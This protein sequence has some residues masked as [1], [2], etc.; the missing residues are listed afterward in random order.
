MTTKDYYFGEWVHIYDGF[1]LEEA[2]QY[3]GLWKRVILKKL[4]RAE[5]D[6]EETMHRPA[7]DSMFW[8]ETLGLKIKVKGVVGEYK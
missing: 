7:S 6:E 3:L 4:R 1:S 5:P 2:R 8:P